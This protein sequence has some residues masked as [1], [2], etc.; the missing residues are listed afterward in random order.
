[1]PGCRDESS[2]I[3]LQAIFNSLSKQQN[4]LTYCQ[5]NKIV[6]GSGLKVSHINTGEIHPAY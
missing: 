6:P 5:N 2:K 1:M 4:V 3:Q